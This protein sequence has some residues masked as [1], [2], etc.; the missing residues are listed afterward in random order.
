MKKDNV[1]Y[2]LL[3]QEANFMILS[4]PIWSWIE[5]MKWMDEERQCEQSLCLTLFIQESKFMLL[6]SP[7]WSWIECMKHMTITWMQDEQVVDQN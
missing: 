6:S 3:I 7:I 2:P 4:S 5:Y 1:S